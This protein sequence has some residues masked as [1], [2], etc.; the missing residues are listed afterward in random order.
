MQV[1]GLVCPRRFDAMADGGRGQGHGC[2][3]STD[4]VFVLA[5]SIIMLN[6]DLHNPSVRHRMTKQDFVR[7]NR[8]IDKGQ[9]VP[10]KVLEVRAHPGVGTLRRS[11]QAH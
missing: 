6:T 7:N 1:R 5:F 4:T 9:D 11:Q 10:S 3:G 2:A 8:G